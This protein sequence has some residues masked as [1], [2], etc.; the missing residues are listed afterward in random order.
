MSQ[1][2]RRRHVHPKTGPG[3]TVQAAAVG[4][5]VSDIVARHA[6][7]QPVGDPRATRQPRFMVMPSQSYHDML[8]QV[9][10]VQT[11]FSSLSARL[12]GKFH[13]S[14]YQLLRWLEEPNN[15]PEALE[16]GLVVPTPE[17]AQE[18]AQKAARARRTEQVDLIRE[19][20]K[21]EAPKADPEAQ[22]DYA[23]TKGKEGGTK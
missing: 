21:S 22:P 18:L 20:M 10:D 12:K 7:G 2:V 3:K 23:R 16:L 8:N 5:R 19:A 6:P 11:T 17:E 15:R 9:T 4:N 14:P 13:N 1:D